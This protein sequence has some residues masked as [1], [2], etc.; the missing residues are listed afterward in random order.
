[1]VAALRPEP[2]REFVRVHVELLAVAAQDVAGPREQ[3]PAFS[4]A[5]DQVAGFLG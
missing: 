3:I 5:T 2:L 4:S 1:M